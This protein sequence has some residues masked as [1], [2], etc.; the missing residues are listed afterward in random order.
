MNIGKAEYLRTLTVSTLK[1]RSVPIGTELDGSSPP[2]I[3]IGSAGY[4]K[5]YAGPLITPEHGDTVVYDT[6]ELWIPGHK[7][8]EEIIG[9]RLNLVRGKRLVKTTDI[10]SRFVS[11]LQEIALSDS[12][13]ESEAAFHEVPT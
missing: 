8:Q 2:S 12:S 4:P 5:V 1:S 9:Y 13:V 3:F 6:P 11:Q 10:H 7:S